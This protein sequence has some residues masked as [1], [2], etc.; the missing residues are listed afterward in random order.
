MESRQATVSLSLDSPSNSRRR[1]SVSFSRQLSS[2]LCAASTDCLHSM[3]FLNCIPAHLANCFSASVSGNTTTSPTHPTQILLNGARETIGG[4]L[5]KRRRTDS[6]RPEGSPPSP[7]R[8][9]SKNVAATPIQQRQ[10]P[11]TSIPVEQGA[12]NTASETADASAKV[13]HSVLDAHGEGSN[14]LQQPLTG[15]L[16][17]GNQDAPDFNTVIAD[18]IN[19]GETVDSNYA[20]RYYD[21]YMAD[22]GDFQHISASFTLKTQS[23]PVLE[24]LVSFCVSLGVTKF[25]KPRLPKSSRLWPD[26]PIMKFFQLPQSLIQILAKLM[27]P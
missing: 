12:Q 22:S 3:R 1:E 15:D 7:K 23:L 25:D 6:L 21:E 27:R 20:A 5:R 10:D 17:G 11:A 19:H 2:L 14:A 8:V 18:I 24:N 4:R 9:Q 16:S 13:D 26:R